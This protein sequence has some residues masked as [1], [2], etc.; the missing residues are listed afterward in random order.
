MDTLNSSISYVFKDKWW[1]KKCSMQKPIQLLDPSS[2]K[3]RTTFQLVGVG[4]VMK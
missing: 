2:E 3:R 4:Y 1:V